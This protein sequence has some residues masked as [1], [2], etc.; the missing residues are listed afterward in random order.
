MFLVGILYWTRSYNVGDNLSPIIVQRILHKKGLHLADMKRGHRLL[1]I[2]S[3]LQL[4]RDGDTVW[5]S[6]INGRANEN[7]YRFTSLDV[8]AVRGPLTRHFLLR[9]G[10]ACPAIY[11]DPAL[12]IPSLFPEFKIKQVDR[13][14]YIVIPHFEEIGIFA[15]EPNTLY[16]TC[17]WREFCSKLLTADL[18]I[19]SSLHGI[20]VAEA[21]GIPA[22]LL[23]IT[24]GEPMLKY[25]DYYYGTGRNAFAYANSV[26]LAREMG[27]EPPP[28]FD[29]Q[30][31]LNTFPID[32]W[33][34]DLLRI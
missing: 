10:V 13:R 15:R 16:P 32:L 1:A 33:D 22:R 2:G 12:L 31:L 17:H 34:N 19:S 14:E 7:E 30:G 21:F 8:R 23:R 4:A 24:N 28:Q 11:G 26:E 6:G 20:I 3:I 5:G 9:R 27:G 18:I 25:E 29:A